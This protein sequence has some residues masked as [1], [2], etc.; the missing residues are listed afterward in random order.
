MEQWRLIHFYIFFLGSSRVEL[1][2]IVFRSINTKVNL[3]SYVISYLVGVCQCLHSI[4]R[5]LVCSSGLSCKH[6]PVGL[7]AVMLLSASQISARLHYT[8]GCQLSPSPHPPLSRF[9]LRH[10][11]VPTLPKGGGGLTVYQPCQCPTL[12]QWLSERNVCG[13]QWHPPGKMTLN[14]LPAEPTDLCQDPIVKS[15]EHSSHILAAQN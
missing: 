7:F 15:N 12:T 11:G 9:W 2:G 5:L 4:C 10:T 14:S 3:F 8:S 13:V 6:F 1:C